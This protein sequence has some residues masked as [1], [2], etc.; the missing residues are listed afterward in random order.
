[1]S[2]YLFRS[3][4][5]TRLRVAHVGS[6]AGRKLASGRKV[7]IGAC[8]RLLQSR[9]SS[10]KLFRTLLSSN[11]IPHH[12]HF[13]LRRMTYG[14]CQFMQGEL[15]RA[16]ITPPSSPVWHLHNISLL[17]YSTPSTFS[18]RLSARGEPSPP[19]RFGAV[20]INNCQVISGYPVQSGGPQTTLGSSFLRPSHRSWCI[21]GAINISQLYA[22]QAPASV[23]SFFPHM[24]VA[25]S[26]I[27]SNNGV[28]VVTTGPKK[29]R[30]MLTD[31][32]SAPTLTRYGRT[33]PIDVQLCAH[34]G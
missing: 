28:Y 18:L 14:K 10:E 6:E 8:P 7:S 29:L 20:S 25:A 15:W 13:L 24:V 17:F 26:P 11:S 16:T 9:Y 34:A 32:Y 23:C 12:V 27:V 1:M 31:A 2:L 5:W 22:T 33:I 4:G 3:W 19:P 21:F 30:N